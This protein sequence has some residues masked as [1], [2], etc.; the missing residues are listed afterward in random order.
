MSNEVQIIG[1]GCAAFSFAA[2]ANEI[3]QNVTLIKP[4]NAPKQKDHVWGFWSDPMLS[5]AQKIAKST[6]EKWAIITDKDSVVL[7]SK[8]KPYNAFKRSDWINHCRSLAEGS[9]VKIIDESDWNKS[10]GANLFDTRPPVVP[11]GC[12][13]QHFHGIEIS[14]TEEKFDPNMAILMDFR[15]D[16]STGL[17][18]IYLLPYSKTEAL[19]ESTLFSPNLVEKQYYLDTIKSYLSKNYQIDQY[20]TTHEENGVIP[21][22]K[23]ALHDP[24]IPGLGTNGGATRPASG[25]TFLFIQR[26]IDAAIKSANSGRGLR[27][28]NPHKRIDMW[29]DSIFLTVLKHWPEYG[30]RIFLGMGK[31]L[32][33]EQFAKFL[34]GD[35]GWWIRLKVIFAMPKW[36]FIKALTKNILPT[37]KATNPVVA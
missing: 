23:L 12:I 7:E 3:T 33:G 18:F 15:V 4:S 31:A 5:S 22:G 26:Q 10:T 28:K 20:K 25:Y 13:L 35:A 34:S 14:T 17:H 16:Q 2:R 9:N 29:M 24:D 36:P 32:N 30:A 27:F 1:D 19:I 11:S 21:L 37:R 8:T 6:W